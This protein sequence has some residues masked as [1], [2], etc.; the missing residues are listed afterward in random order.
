ME[1][2]CQLLKSLLANL[3]IIYKAKYEK[4]DTQLL[5]IN[6]SPEEQEI[7]E[8]ICM[9]TFNVMG[10]KGWAR[11]DLLQDLEGEFYVLEINTVPGHDFS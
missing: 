4:D 2:A 8:S 9:N 10:C 6:Y 3:S 5:Q 7:L 11:I 1:D